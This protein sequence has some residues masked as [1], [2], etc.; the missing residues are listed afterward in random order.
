MIHA[1]GPPACAHQGRGG[2]PATGGTSRPVRREGRSTLLGWAFAVQI[3]TP[4][5]IDSRWEPSR[6]AILAAAAVGGLTA[7]WVSL[8]TLPFVATQ[9]V[10]LGLLITIGVQKALAY[11][12]PAPSAMLI[13]VV[14]ATVG[15]AVADLL[16]NRQVPSWVKARGCSAS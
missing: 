4:G 10:A 1:A 13:G 8:S 7:H 2:E 16:T 5:G 12:T 9:A 6:P 15:A 3:K 14:A 11:H